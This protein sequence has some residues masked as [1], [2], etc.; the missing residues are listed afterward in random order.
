MARLMEVLGKAD[1]LPRGTLCR[2]RRRP[3]AAGAEI[4]QVLVASRRAGILGDGA[5]AEA[6]QTS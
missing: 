6:L 4:I 3:A 5:H 1:G 2:S